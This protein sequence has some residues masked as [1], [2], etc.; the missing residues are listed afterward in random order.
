MNVY[1][2]YINGLPVGTIE[3]TNADHA[4][5]LAHDDIVMCPDHVST[6]NIWVELLISMSDAT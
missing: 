6:D 1:E 2:I 3:A 4:R 5:Q